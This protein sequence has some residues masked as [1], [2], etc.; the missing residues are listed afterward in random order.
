MLVAIHLAIHDEGSGLLRNGCKNVVKE[1][2]P[3]LIIWVSEGLWGKWE[4]SFKQF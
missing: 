4:Q 1:T 2:K 3:D